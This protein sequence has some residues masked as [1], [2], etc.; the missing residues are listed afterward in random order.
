MSNDSGVTISKLVLLVTTS[1]VAY[2]I[3]QVVHNVF[4]HPLSRFPGPVFA[5]ITVYWKAYVEC[6]ADRSFCHEL[7]KLHARYGKTSVPCCRTG[8]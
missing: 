4:F 7:E 6:I 1:L 2:A 5:K 8:V 3:Y